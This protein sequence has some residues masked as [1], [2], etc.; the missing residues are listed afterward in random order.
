MKE[1][2]KDVFKSFPVLKTDRLTLREITI[3]DA[4][5]IFEMRTNDNVM[6]M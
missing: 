6:T 4:E 2:N 3:K 1:L 5:A